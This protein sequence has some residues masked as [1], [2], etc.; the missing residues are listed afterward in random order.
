MF[1]KYLSAIVMGVLLLQSFPA[2][3]DQWNR[4]S[5]GRERGFVARRLGPGYRSIL[6]RGHSYLYDGGLFYRYSPVGYIIVEPPLGAL[7]PALP[8]GYRT[9]T[10][11][12]KPYYFYEDTYYTVAPG[13]YV[14]APP[15]VALPA[16]PAYVQE[17]TVNP[18]APRI[19]QRSD[20]DTYEI[21]IPNVDG[22]Y[23]LV[24]LKKVEKGFVGPQGEFYPEH[25]TVEK[26]K[27]L[28]G[29]K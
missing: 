7:V 1:K 3:A 4:H 6:W 26:L 23:T 21:H 29:K 9:V 28:Y 24:E 25:P 8:Y 18:A 19:E 22:S 17:K 12:H 5:R 15:P 27:V 2:S 11:E 20:I 14:V 13:G 16:Q 10:V